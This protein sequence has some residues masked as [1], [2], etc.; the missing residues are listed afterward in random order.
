MAT[1]KQL[2]HW[3]SLKGKPSWNKG[4]KWSKEHK[5]KLSEV[6]TKSYLN[7]RIHSS[8]GKKRFD[9]TGDKNPLWK[10][11]RVQLHP[12]EGRLYNLMTRKRNARSV[13]ESL[14]GLTLKKSQIVHHINL[15]SSDDRPENLYL[16]R[17]ISAHI[18]WHSYIKRNNLTGTILKSNLGLY[19]TIS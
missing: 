6:H 11:N 10:E 13:V 8:L 2:K 15:I 3:E 7:G 16:F 4:K 1:E 18:K 9:M 12:S 14:T 19:D 17:T 5:K